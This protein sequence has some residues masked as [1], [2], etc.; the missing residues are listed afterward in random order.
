MSTFY[1]SDKFLIIFLFC[2]QIY[3]YFCHFLFYFRHQACER[4]HHCSGRCQDGRPWPGQ[5]LLLQDGGGGVAGGDAILHV[6]RED[7]RE[8]VR[9][10]KNGGSFVPLSGKIQRY[11]RNYFLAGKK[12]EAVTCLSLNLTKTPTRTFL[13]RKGEIFHWRDFFPDMPFSLTDMREFRMC[14]V[15]YTIDA[16]C[17]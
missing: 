3:F 16:W 6:A 1:M 2:G 5:V 12:G 4:V 15:V 8:G 17:D 10:L 7:T 13:Q 9:E 11:M 14:S